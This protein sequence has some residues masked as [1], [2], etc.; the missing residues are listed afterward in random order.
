MQSEVHPERPDAAA[1]HTTQ[2]LES[3]LR[4]PRLEACLGIQV[5]S[6]LLRAG[7]I[8]V[9]QSVLALLIRLSVEGLYDMTLIQN[10]CGMS[11]L[12][13]MSQCFVTFQLRLMRLC[14]H[15]E[16]PPHSCALDQIRKGS[17]TCSLP[18]L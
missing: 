6:H 7:I 16:E 4:L 13:G 14:S 8:H 5:V 17:P 15:I 9:L 1:D 2:S 3:T 10:T 11:W 18:W 12:Q